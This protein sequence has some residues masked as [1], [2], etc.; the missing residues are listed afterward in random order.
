MRFLCLVIVDPARFEGLTAAD[1]QAI[2]ADSLA[3]DDELKARGILV[4]AHALGEPQTATT[5]RARGDET[6]YTDGPFAELKEHVGGFILIDV[7]DRDEA[8]AVASRIPMARYGAIEVR[9]V[10]ALR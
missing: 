10:R 5:I 7:R 6:F 1:H 2:T 9:E 3:Y 4:A 8:L